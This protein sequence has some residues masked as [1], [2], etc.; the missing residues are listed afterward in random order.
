MMPMKFDHL[1]GRSARLGRPSIK[2]DPDDWARAHRRYG[3]SSGSPGPRDPSLTPYMIPFARAIAS[4]RWRR[5]V[6][7]CAAQTGK[8][9]TLLDVIGQRLDQAPC[10]VMYVGPGRQF[11]D[12]RFVPSGMQL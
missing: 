3:P 1:F 5:A 8:T 9:E 11:V 7:C 4:R 10:P 12:E 2:T 6:M